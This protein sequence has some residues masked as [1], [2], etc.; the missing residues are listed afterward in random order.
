MINLLISI[1]SM[2]DSKP[3]QV[4]TIV[5]GT[6]VGGGATPDEVNAAEAIVAFVKANGTTLGDWTMVKDLAPGEDDPGEGE[7]LWKHSKPRR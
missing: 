5:M 7:T 2:P 6:N 1:R 3:G 4:N